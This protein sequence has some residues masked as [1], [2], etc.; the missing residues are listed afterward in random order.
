MKE[1]AM[2]ALLIGVG[3]VWG[4]LCLRLDVGFFGNLVGGIIIGWALGSLLKPKGKV[5]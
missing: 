2:L 3:L 5:N 1:I 4:Y